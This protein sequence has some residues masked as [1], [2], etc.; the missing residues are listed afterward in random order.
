MGMDKEKKRHFELSCIHSMESNGRSW[1]RS[2]V[3]GVD[4]GQL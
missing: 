1:G 3:P 2:S 4:G